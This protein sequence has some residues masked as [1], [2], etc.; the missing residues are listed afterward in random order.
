MY[1][2]PPT[3]LVATW[4]PDGMWSLLAEGDPLFY[5]SYMHMHKRIGR[6]FTDGDRARG[7]LGERRHRGLA[8]P[9]VEGK[10]VFTV[11]PGTLEPQELP[12]RL[13]RAPRAS[14]S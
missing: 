13:K 5:S 1:E 7:H 14:R 12:R 2:R 6:R 8:L 9:L 3:R 10:D 4:T 11:L